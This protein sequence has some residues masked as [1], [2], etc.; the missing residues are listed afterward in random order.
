MKSLRS[1]PQKSASF[2]FKNFFCPRSD[3]R[4]LFYLLSFVF[5]LAPSLAGAA[6]VSLTWGK[7]T[8]AAGYKMHYGNYSGSYQYT[9]NIGNSTSCT[10]SGLTEGETYY[11]AATAYD[12]QQNKSGYSNEVVN[13]VGKPAGTSDI[14]Q[15][16]PDWCRDYGPC[17]EGQGDCDGDAECQSGL[18]CA[19]DV[20]ADYGWP[21][22]RDVCERP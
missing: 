21:A 14:F 22:G 19:Q 13:T 2:I 6:Q 3:I 7:S 1:V 20:G 16:G 4:F 10:I 17:P 12:S 18:I 9:V 11:F 5:I 15:P 8:G